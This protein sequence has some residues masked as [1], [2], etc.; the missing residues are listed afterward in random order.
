MRQN[1]MAIDGATSEIRRWRKRKKK[2]TTAL[3]HNSL[4]GSTTTLIVVTYLLRTR[5]WMIFN[6]TILSAKSDNMLVIL[7]A[8]RIISHTFYSS[9]ISPQQYQHP[10]SIQLHLVLVCYNSLHASTDNY[11]FRLAHFSVRHL[12]N[13]RRVCLSVVCLSVCPTSDLEN[14]ATQARNFV[15]FIGDQGQRARIWRQILHRKLLSTPPSPQKKLES[16]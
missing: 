9:R 8:Y 14:Y 11:L 16:R 5:L 10:S 2:S 15:I 4:R 13:G 6:V 12:W 3:K 7:N 1:V